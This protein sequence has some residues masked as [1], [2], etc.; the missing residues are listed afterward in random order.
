MGAK[1]AREDQ[2][3][4]SEAIEVLDISGYDILAE[5]VSRAAKN[6]A[7]FEKWARQDAID[8][9]LP[10]EDLDYS[11]VTKYY[12][13]GGTTV[14]EAWDARIPGKDKTFGE[15]AED[16]SPETIHFPDGTTGRIT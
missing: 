16:G 5:R 8:H 15:W 14:H 13:G 12:N 4:L 7:A 11:V 10:A 6:L 2:A 9:G 1:E 3:A